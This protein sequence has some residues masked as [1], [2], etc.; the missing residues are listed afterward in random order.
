MKKDGIE[1]TNTTKEDMRIY[2]LE[3]EDANNRKICHCL[4]KLGA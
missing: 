1:G 3:K 2:E 4:I